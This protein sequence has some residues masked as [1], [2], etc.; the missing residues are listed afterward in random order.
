MLEIV[1]LK[2]VNGIAWLAWAVVAVLLDEKIWR[3]E[4]VA[5]II[6][7]A[8]TSFYLIPA[9]EQYIWATPEMSNFFWFVIWF[10]AR[11]IIV[12]LRSKF[13]DKIGEKI[14]EL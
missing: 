7:W 1:W 14:D 4:S 9:I 5:I 12:K 11:A 13:I 8:I 6:I 2:L 10:S 3:K